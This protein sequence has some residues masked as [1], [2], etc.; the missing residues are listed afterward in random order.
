M[1]VLS[2]RI[3]KDLAQRHT[4]RD[5][6]ISVNPPAAP[7]DVALVYSVSP[8]DAWR[9]MLKNAL[10]CSEAASALVYSSRGASHESDCKVLQNSCTGKLIAAENRLQSRAGKVDP[11]ARDFSCDLLPVPRGV[12]RRQQ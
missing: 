8:D 1:H 9:L 12:D 11:R 7:A 5:N 3:Q 10:L 2:R 4:R 6:S